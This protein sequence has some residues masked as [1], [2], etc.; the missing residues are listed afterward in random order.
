MFG[1]STES[2]PERPLTSLIE[3]E[4][5]ADPK[6]LENFIL[7]NS[8]H[9]STSVHSNVSNENHELMSA[10]RSRRLSCNL[11]NISESKKDRNWESNDIMKLDQRT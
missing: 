11:P 7:D 6:H 10:P 3:S 1:T 4:L 8:K 5:S 9:T 2:I